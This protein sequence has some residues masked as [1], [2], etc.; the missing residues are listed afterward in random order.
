MGIKLGRGATVH[1]DSI[2]SQPEDSVTRC[3]RSADMVKGTPDAVTCKSCIK[4]TERDDAARSIGRERTERKTE[5]EP[6]TV[7]LYATT[8]EV[9]RLSADYVKADESAEPRHFDYVDVFEAATR[10]NQGTVTIAL[11]PQ[12]TAVAPGTT[13]KV[14]QGPGVVEYHT[15]PDGGV[16][17]VNVT[18]TLIHKPMVRV[19]ETMTVEEFQA[20]AVKIIEEGPY[21]DPATPAY[22]AVADAIL[23][24]IAGGPAAVP[25]QDGPVRWRSAHGKR[26]IVCQRSR[27]HRK[28]WG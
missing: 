3:G 4:L 24:A 10:N 21:R 16:D 12:D 18:A 19:V 28:A 14:F 8:A 9:R 6:E 17:A 1:A 11:R 5:S 26:K 15:Y 20:E 22:N 7:E 2:E 13:K 25:S 23:R 27:G